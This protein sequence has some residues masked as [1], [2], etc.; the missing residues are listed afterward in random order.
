MGGIWRMVRSR[1]R[2]ARFSTHLRRAGDRNMSNKW[3]RW[4]R[5]EPLRSVLWLDGHRRINVF[6]SDGADWHWTIQGPGGR[7]TGDWV[8]LSFGASRTEGGARFQAIEN[9]I[10]RGFMDRPR[11][12]AERSVRP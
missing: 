6:R 2:H 1:C 8:T 5:P 9:A 12:A 4:T 3:T 10:E 7:S 11:S